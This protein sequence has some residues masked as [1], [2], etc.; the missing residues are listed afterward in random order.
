MEVPILASVFSWMDDND[1]DYGPMMII[2]DL[3]LILLGFFLF[4]VSAADAFSFFIFLLPIWLPVVLFLVFFSKW[5]E[6]VGKKFWAN[7]GRTTLRI[8]PPQEVFKSPEAMEFVL[9]QIHNVAN[10]DNLMQTYLDG[11]R[12]L[13]FSLEIV[14]IGGEV[15]F[16]VN[17]PT[18]KT[19][20]AFEANMYAQYPGVEIIEEPVDYA[21]EVPISFDP[22][23][24]TVF[25]VHMGKKKDGFLPIKTY[26]DYG[27]DKLPKEE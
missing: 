2:I 12:P 27:L 21:G 5:D 15:R 9:A 1:M 6:A 17:V 19:R 23:K 22:S 4:G 8:I 14:S 13:D 25:S 26:I 24:T 3:F 10:P 18:K 16:Y 20:D 11:K 7:Q